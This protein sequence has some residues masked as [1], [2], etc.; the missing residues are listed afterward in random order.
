MQRLNSVELNKRAEFTAI[1]FFDSCMWVDVEQPCVGEFS[2][3]DG[4]KTE[5]HKNKNVKIER[6]TVITRLSQFSEIMKCIYLF[7]YYYSLV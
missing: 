1:I 4:D 3:R 7:I 2:E 6:V 5:E